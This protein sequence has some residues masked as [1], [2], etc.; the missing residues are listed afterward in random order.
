V[1]GRSERAGVADGQVYRRCGLDACSRMD[2][3][4]WE[5]GKSSRSFSTS[6]AAMA[7]WC[8]SSLIWAATRG[9]TRSTA[10]VPITGD[11]LLAQRGKDRV[12]QVHRVLAAEVSGP[13]QHVSR[14]GGPQAGGPGEPDE[15]LQDQGQ[16]GSREDTFQG[17]ENL[18]QQGAQAVDRGCAL[19]GQI[20][21]ESGEDLQRREPLAVPRHA[22]C[23]A[24]RVRS[25]R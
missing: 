18:Q 5:R 1:P 8:L 22:V 7:R 12:D 14:T 23:A 13:A 15:Q 20:G 6:S 24:S 25:R 2:I 21:V 17:G 9:M 10:S 16:Y 11:R 19:V 3:K 4:T